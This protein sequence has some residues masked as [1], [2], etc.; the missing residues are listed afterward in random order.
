MILFVDDE[1]RRMSPYVDACRDSG[2]KTEFKSDV[3]AAWEFVS[4]HASEINLLVLDVM[5]PTGA[6]YDEQSQTVG[7]VRTGLTFYRDVREKNPELPILIL[8]QSNDLEIDNTADKD[9]NALVHRK[10]N[11]LPSELPDIIRGMLDARRKGG[12]R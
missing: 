1:T 8:T 5:L 12:R 3:D 10:Q 11:V 2:L 6:R 7:G 4:H 9:Q